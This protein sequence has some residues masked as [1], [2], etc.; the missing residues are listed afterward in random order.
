MLNTRCTHLKTVLPE[1][2]NKDEKYEIVY[3]STESCLYPQFL[4]VIYLDIS[5]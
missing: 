2:V 4:A 3:V 1:M 5:V